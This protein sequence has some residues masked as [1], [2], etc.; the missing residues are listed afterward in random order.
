MSD[1]DAK[2]GRLMIECAKRF[3]YVQ[4]GVSQNFL[5]QEQYTIKCTAMA[6]HQ[7]F[8]SVD[9]FRV[10]DLTAMSDPAVIA[11]LIQNKIE[12]DNGLAKGAAAKK[13]STPSRS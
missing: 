13:A 5:G 4:L 11:D 1:T 6:N 7:T 10:E 3:T 12:T 9:M 8:T 2:L